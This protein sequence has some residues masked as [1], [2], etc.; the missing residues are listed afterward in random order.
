MQNELKSYESYMENL[1]LLIG[2]E[3]PVTL[4]D[5]NLLHNNLDLERRLNLTMQPWMINLLE[6]GTLR[7]LRVYSYKIRG[8]NEVLRR[9]A[10]GMYQQLVLLLSLSVYIV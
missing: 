6:E 7:K 5:I 8:Y 2:K 10:I 9:T 3:S 4:N 1:R